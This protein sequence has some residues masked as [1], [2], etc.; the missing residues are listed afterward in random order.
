MSGNTVERAR[1]RWRDI[2]PALGVAHRFLANKHGPCP[3]CGGKDRFRYDDKEGAGTY[4]C[5]QCGAGTGIIML[6]KMHG[7][8]HATAC[9]EVDK[10]IGAGDRVPRAV[11]KVESKSADD[12]LAAINRLLDEATSDAVVDR[13]LVRRGLSVRS[14][15][16]RGHPRCQYFD[17]DRKLQGRHPAV[18]APIIGPDGNLQS[19]QRI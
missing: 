1:G 19:A 11:V 15:V 7:W 17:A 10:I 18:V 6:R 14:A 2:L 4:I 13:Y 8:D 9:R 16:L 12:R 5:G 3:I